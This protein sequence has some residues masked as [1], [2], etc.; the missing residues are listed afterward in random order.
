MKW[1]NNF[2]VYIDYW[3]ESGNIVKFL[4]WLDGF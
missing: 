4:K 2:L 1:S 3:V